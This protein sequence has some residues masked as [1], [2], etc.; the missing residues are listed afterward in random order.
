MARIPLIKRLYPLLAACLLAAGCSGYQPDY[1]PASA[2]REVAPLTAEIAAL[3]PQ[4]DPEEAARAARIALTY[5]LELRQRY[6]VSDPPLVHNTKVNMGLRPRG[7][8]K[9]WADDMEARLAAEGFRTL[10]LHRAIANADTAR[11]EHS[12]VIVSAMGEGPYE[13]LVL[14][15]W[16]YG[17]DLHWGPVTADPDYR[18]LP[19]QAAFQARRERERAKEMMAIGT[20]KSL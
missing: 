7:L 2:M 15:P 1:A 16:R 3:S 13:G 5:P 18:W 19:R 8:C 11:I 9:D 10:T 20:R 17:G 14:D 4:V 6:E 12:T